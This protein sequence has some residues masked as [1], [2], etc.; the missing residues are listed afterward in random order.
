MCH[1]DHDAA[2]ADQWVR[3]WYPGDFQ[4]EVLRRAELDRPG[5]Q[6]AV[7]APA[8]DA[9]RPAKAN[10][11]E[12]YSTSLVRLLA[13]CEDPRKWPVLLGLL[14]DPVAAGPLQRG[15]GLG[16]SPHARGPRRPAGGRRRSVAAGADSH[17]DV[18]GG[19]AAG[20]GQDERQRANLQQAN[21]EFITAMQARPDDWSSHANLG[22][23]YMDGRDF[24]AAAA[25]FETAST[26]EPRQVG[27]M[28]NASMAYSN[29]HENQKAEQCLRQ[30][31]KMDPTNA[32]GNFN[33]GLLL[34]EQGHMPEAEQALRTALKADPQMA[35]AAFN[36]GVLLGDKDLDAAI[37]FCQQAH[38]LRP[39]DAKYAHTL[40]FYERKKGDLAGAI[41]LLREV[42]QSEPSYLDA[43]LL[44]GEIYEERHDAAA[45]AKIISTP[46][47]SS[48][49]RRRPATSWKR[50]PG[51][52]DRAVRASSLC[53]IIDVTSAREGC[54]A[55]E[56]Q[57]R[58]AQ[59]VLLGSKSAPFFPQ[60]FRVRA[61][62]GPFRRRRS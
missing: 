38:E 35:A 18:A 10:G 4:A 48:N 39:G 42:I 2:W 57:L 59:Q 36:L 47:A 60:D 45:A 27:P 31:L 8:R 22:N 53:Q 58:I 6:A 34:A 9:G 54:F 5:P 37:A 7:A 11:D 30:A 23:F 3:K 55:P 16:R 56:G 25:S 52:C 43:Y 24:A 33:L 12:V 40:A 13:G 44:L 62:H 41:E 26:L 61:V 51:A 49:C 15:R 32:A 21:A 50:E 1:A 17:R 19:P 46:H 29:L 14:E 20:M 28:V